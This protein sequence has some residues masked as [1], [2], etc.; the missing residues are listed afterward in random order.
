MKSTAHVLLLSLML[1]GCGGGSS[2]APDMTEDQASTR[3]GLTDSS[4]PASKPETGSFVD[5]PVSGISYS[6]DSYSG[7][8]DDNGTFRY[9]AGEIVEFSIGDLVLGSAVANSTITPLELGTQINGDLNYENNHQD[10][11]T[12]TLRLLQTLDSDSYPENG[13]SISANTASAINTLATNTQGLGSDNSD[14]VIDF[15]LE[16]SAFETQ[17][18]LIQLLSVA[19][20]SG[21]LVSSEK[22][23]AHFKET[24]MGLE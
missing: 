4:M 17:A 5:S 1:T 23:I 24:L 10:R 22:A 19:T 8:T 20:N 11:A 6:T 9:L 21:I 12:N 3:G 16:G 14:V 15:N 13:I 7:L 18:S 2:N